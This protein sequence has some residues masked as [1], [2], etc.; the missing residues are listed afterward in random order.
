[1]NAAL[2]HD[3]SAVLAAAYAGANTSVTAG[4]GGDATEVDGAYVLVEDA[5]GISFLIGFTAT[6]GADETLTIAGNL[7]DAD[8]ASGTG[9]ADYGTA[10]AATVVATGPSGGGT[11]TGVAIVTASTAGMREACRVQF[12]PNLSAGSTDTAAL[13]CVAIMGGAKRLP[14]AFS[15]M[16]RLN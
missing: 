11:V 12:T 4:G 14:A 8:D 6:L 7:Q 9:V 15:N 13:S 3:P 2:L 5:E 16:T 1:M 10:I